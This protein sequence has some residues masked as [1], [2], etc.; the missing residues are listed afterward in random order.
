MYITNLTDEVTED[1]M[2]ELFGSIG[3]IK[4]WLLTVETCTHTHTHTHTQIKKN[5]GTNTLDNITCLL[6]VYFQQNRK[7]Q[8]PSITLY[9][10]KRTGKF[11]VSLVP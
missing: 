6:F 1:K 4:V 8:K 11:K 9:T 2:G 10:D 3:V 7:T 5:P